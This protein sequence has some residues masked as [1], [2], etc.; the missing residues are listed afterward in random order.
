MTRIS[1]FFEYEGIPLPLFEFE[2]KI[3]QG[4]K[5][6][7]DYNYSLQIQHTLKTNVKVFESDPKLREEITRKFLEVGFI[8]VSDHITNIFPDGNVVKT[9][10]RLIFRSPYNFD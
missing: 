9:Y 4:N 2:Y 6:D 1:L 5:P 3:D 8:F 7:R 10:D